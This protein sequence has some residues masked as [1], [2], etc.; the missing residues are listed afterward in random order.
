[1]SVTVGSVFWCARLSTVCLH[2][3]ICILAAVTSCTVAAWDTIW[4]RCYFNVQSP[5]YP[6]KI[7]LGLGKQVYEHTNLLLIVSLL[8][9]LC[10]IWD[11]K[12]VQYMSGSKFLGRII[13]SSLSWLQDTGGCRSWGCADASM[14]ELSFYSEERPLVFLKRFMACSILLPM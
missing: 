5:L 13:I 10:I 8:Q 12:A 4:R 11:L 2:K 3:S 6:V 7:Q 9:R 1:M 14:P